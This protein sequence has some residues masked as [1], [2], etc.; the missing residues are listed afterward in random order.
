[1]ALL[2]LGTHNV[3]DLIVYLP[4]RNWLVL[5]EAAP[6]H[7]PVDEKRYGE[8]R[9][10]FGTSSAELVLVSCFPSR[11]DMRK[12][13]A[14]IAWETEVVRGRSVALDPF[15]RRALSRA[16]RQRGLDEQ[17]GTLTQPW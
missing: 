2:D 14:V 8:L 6:S 15:R 1:M 7:G 4:E 5:M 17:I 3:C 11:A 10:L 9:A 12:H 13:L 16:V